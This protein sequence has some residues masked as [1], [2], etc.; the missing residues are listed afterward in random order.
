MSSQLE[1]S[2][3]VTTRSRPPSFYRSTDQ[4]ASSTSGSP[5]Y[6]TAADQVTELLRRSGTNLVLRQDSASDN[7][8]NAVQQLDPQNRQANKTKQTGDASI[9][10]PSQVGLKFF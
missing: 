8:L 10:K 4:V 9:S 7:G 5:L 2:G 6:K 1:S 3:F